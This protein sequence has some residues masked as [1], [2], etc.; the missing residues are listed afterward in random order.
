MRL[1]PLDEA[2]D[3]YRARLETAIKQV[4]SDLT[5]PPGDHSTLLMDHPTRMEII[6]RHA[7]GNANVARR[8]F[9]RDDLFLEPLPSPDAP[10]A[11]MVLPQDATALMRDY[12]APMVRGMIKQYIDSPTKI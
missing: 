1:L 4:D 10:L 8:Y 3:K 9:G 2:P 11:Q 12:V 7:E 5:H 6:R